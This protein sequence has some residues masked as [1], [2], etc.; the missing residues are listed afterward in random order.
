MDGKVKKQKK[1]SALSHIFVPKALLLLIIGK[2]I[3]PK[4]VNN[5]TSIYGGSAYF[6]LSQSWS[7]KQVPKKKPRFG[8]RTV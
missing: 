5:Y 1:P 4:M 6:F 7:K 8:Q 3:K 2:K